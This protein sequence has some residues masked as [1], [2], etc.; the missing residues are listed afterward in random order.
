MFAGRIVRALLIGS[1][2]WRELKATLDQRIG[3]L[4]PFTESIP[5]MYIITMVGLYEKL[6]KGNK[7]WTREVEGSGSPGHVLY[8][9]AIVSS[10]FTA[11]FGLMK[12]FKNG[13]TR[14]LDGL[15]T[16]KT[17]LTFLSTL[18]LNVVKMCLLYMLVTN[19]AAERWLYQVADG[20]TC[21]QIT[22]VYQ[23]YSGQEDVYNVTDK[24]SSV[25]VYQRVWM[26]EDVSK[27]LNQFLILNKSSKGWASSDN[28][29]CV[30]QID[31]SQQDSVP[32]GCQQ[33]KP[34]I[35]PMCGIWYKKAAM[36]PNFMLWSLL[37]VLPHFLL[38]IVVLIWA[39]QVCTIEGSIRE[40]GCFCSCSANCKTLFPLLLQHPQILMT[41]IFSHFTFGPKNPSTR[42]SL[43]ISPLLTWINTLLHLISVTIIAISFLSN[44]IEELP[45][46]HKD[47]KIAAALFVLFSM[48][49]IVFVGFILHLPSLKTE[50]CKIKTSDYWLVKAWSSIYNSILLSAGWGT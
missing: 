27:K 50:V 33:L 16:W 34:R 40:S 44:W 14:F 41:P 15:F 37:C 4:E 8:I 9:S 17:F 19:R 12:F 10:I 30:D 25:D 47:H 49:S 11:N 7:A 6:V 23:K 28:Q 1:E 35:F 36:A 20:E 13:P 43:A 3:T 42:S 45:G 22:W 18:L 29:S 2:N 38:S 31:F 48:T 32:A 39:T 24:F 26:G 5:S 21:P 46:A